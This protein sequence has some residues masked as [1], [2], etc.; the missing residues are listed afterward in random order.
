MIRGEGMENKNSGPYVFLY[1]PEADP[2]YL[3][4]WLGTQPLIVGQ[5][6]LEDY[7]L[8]FAN[9]R[10]GGVV[11]T[12]EYSQGD[13]LPVMVYGFEYYMQRRMERRMGYP[14]GSR[15]GTYSVLVE[16]A[17]YVRALGYLIP[18]VRGCR[19]PDA[20]MVERMRAFYVSRAWDP[21]QVD[22]AVERS[23]NLSPVIRRIK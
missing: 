5:G 10:G 3:E 13:A 8:A 19:E 4:R 16:D 11:P 20:G 23:K 6:V 14:Y 22:S 17:H 12:M 1:G 2:D 15:R 21:G 18:S 9:R 7:R